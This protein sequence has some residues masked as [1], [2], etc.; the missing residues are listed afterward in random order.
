MEMMTDL[1]KQIE[2]RC[3]RAHIGRPEFLHPWVR[4][5]LSHA[6]PDTMPGMSGER[7]KPGVAFWATVMLAVPILYVLSSGPAVLIVDYAQSEQVNEWFG[8]VYAPLNW[9][10]LKGPKPIRDL[11]DWWQHL[12]F[13]R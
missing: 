12:W 5:S 9:L 4:H 3:F 1:Y 13:R 8:W 6:S 2:T 10:Y 7:K 11:L